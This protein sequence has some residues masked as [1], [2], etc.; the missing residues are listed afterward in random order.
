MTGRRWAAEE[1][2]ETGKGPVGWD[3]NQLRKFGSLQKHTALAGL[4]MLR[5]NIIMD[6]LAGR[7]TVISR[8]T[9]PENGDVTAAADFTEKTAKVKR[10]RSRE[11]TWKEVMIPLGDS[12]VP[13]AAG[14]GFPAEIGYVRLSR[15]EVMRLRDAVMNG[16]SSSEIAFH[17]ECSNW[18]RRHQ[19]ISKW[20]H[21]AKRLKTAALTSPQ[22]G[23][24]A[25]RA[26]T[27]SHDRA[28]RNEAQKH[29]ATSRKASRASLYGI[30]EL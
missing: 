30:A 3:Q 21:H 1:G 8:R 12:I 17:V 9:S 18:R 13:K 7:G 27:E 25:R 20:H 16:D 29:A 19:A 26:T 5:S 28:R 22:S 10:E 15:N 2:N 14:A 11:T 24:K 6:R 23:V 4:A